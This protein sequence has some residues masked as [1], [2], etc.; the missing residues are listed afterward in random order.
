[1]KN[2]LF[3]FR[4]GFK[5]LI[6]VIIQDEYLTPRVVLGT[7]R[8]KERL[9]SPVSLSGKTV[10]VIDAYGLLYQVFHAHGMEVLNALGSRPGA[11][12]G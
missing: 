2:Q 7:S 5:Q 8:S 1:M 4:A 11:A 9:M 12:F 6:F 10:C 3:K